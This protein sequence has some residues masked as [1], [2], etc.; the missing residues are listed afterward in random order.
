MEFEGKMIGC[1]GLVCTDCPAYQ[2]T[3]ANDA[4]KI[5]Q[6][7]TE[8]SNQ[9]DANVTPDNVWC[10]G[11]LAGGRKCGHC[12]ECEVRACAIEKDMAN[13]GVC[14]EY[15]DCN[16]IQNFLKMAPLAKAVLDQMRQ[17]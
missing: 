12:H 11:C 4:E 7:A 15:A 6:I 9:Y 8:W 13:C 17:M 16:T 5:A 2:A 10:D 14:S 1:C 3:Q